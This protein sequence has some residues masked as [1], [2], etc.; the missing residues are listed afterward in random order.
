M[1]P[2]VYKATDGKIVDILKLGLNPR[3]DGTKRIV[4]LAVADERIDLLY[5]AGRHIVG[6]GEPEQAFLRLLRRQVAAYL[7][8]DHRQLRPMPDGNTIGS[9][10]PIMLLGGLRKKLGMLGRGYP[11]SSACA[12]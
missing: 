9:P 6:T 8:H 4:G 2:A 12:L 5:L 3:A 7:A 10:L 1:S 11:S